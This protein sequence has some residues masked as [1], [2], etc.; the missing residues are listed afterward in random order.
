MSER[1]NQIRVNQYRS[2]IQ[3]LYNLGV[4]YARMGDTSTA[5]HYMTEAEESPTEIRHAPIVKGLNALKAQ[6]LG[7]VQL[8]VLPTDA[9]FRPARSKVVNI[10]K[11]DYLG[12]AKVSDVDRAL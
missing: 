3:P 8:W 7:A 5:L 10:G 6:N 4:V 2:F 9:I 12:K 1:F 11:K